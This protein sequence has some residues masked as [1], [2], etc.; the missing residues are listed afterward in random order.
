M[1][2]ATP[3][4]ATALALLGA[5]CL[6]AQTPAATPAPTYPPSI[7][8]LVAKTKTEIKVMNLAD[9]KA[10]FDRKETGLIL[11]VREPDEYLVPHPVV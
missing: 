5:A 11:D 2:F 9:F 6:I 3:F 8:Q 10:A 4:R 7:G 1:T